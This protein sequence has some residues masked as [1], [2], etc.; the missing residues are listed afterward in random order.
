MTPPKLALNKPVASALQALLYALMF[1]T[2][3][4]VGSWLHEVDEQT[5]KRAVFFYPL[6]GLVIGCLLTVAALLLMPLGPPLAAALVLMLWVAVTGALHLDGLADCMDAYYAGHKCS[7]AKQRRERILTVMHDPACGAVALVSLVLLLLVKWA[8][9]AALFTLAAS[10]SRFLMVFVLLT[11]SL[12]P[13]LARTIILPFMTL[14]NYARHDGAAAVNAAEHHS[15]YWV[16]TLVVFALC[17]LWLGLLTALA[18]LLALT[19]LML[20]WAQLWRRQIGGYTGDCLGA[21][22]ELA[23]ALTLIVLVALW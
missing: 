18:L 21:L 11:L 8:A 7:D 9:L 15:L 16:I 17:G 12:A 2:R 13:V 5:A 4:P 23:E 14:N 10:S 19:L 22:V 6:V 1:L 20:Y 3:L